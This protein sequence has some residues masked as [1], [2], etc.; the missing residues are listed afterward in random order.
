ML[1]EQGHRELWVDRNVL[2]LNGGIS[3][4]GTVTCQNQ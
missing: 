2:S 4:M 3:Y 1:T